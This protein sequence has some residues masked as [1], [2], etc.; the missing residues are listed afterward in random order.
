MLKSTLLEPPASTAMFH[1]A[2]QFGRLGLP[3][4]LDVNC[5]CLP[6]HS[7][8]RRSW[9]STVG[10]ITWSV[11]IVERVHLNSTPKRSSRSIGV[12]NV[13]LMLSHLPG[14]TTSYTC[15]FAPSPAV[16]LLDVTGAHAPDRN[17]GVP[18]A[19]GRA[20]CMHAWMAWVR[21]FRSKA[22]L[23]PNGVTPLVPVNSGGF[24]ISTFGVI[25]GNQ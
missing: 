1:Y 2:Q 7:Q 13:Y 9:T 20:R 16:G 8:Q 25:A 5:D 19:G 3:W 14:M 4:K 17:L 21:T 12:T 6:W 15:I 11:S 23:V 18:D 10:H 24:T 22:Y